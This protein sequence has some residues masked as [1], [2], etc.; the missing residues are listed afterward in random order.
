MIAAAGGT[1]PAAEAEGD[2]GGAGMAPRFAAERTLGKLAKWLRLMGYDTVLENDFPGGRF[3]P[4]IGRRRVLLT[5][6]RRAPQE[7]AA[8]F[9]AANDPVEQLRELAAAGWVAPGDLKPFSRCLR[10]NAPIER[11]GR[12]EV[13]GL[14]PDY[15]W[16]V[17]AAFS[18]CPVCRR[19]YWRGSHTRRG[20]E[21]IARLFGMEGG[22]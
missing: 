11:V 7:T 15:V 6:R 14:V 16:E 19:V 8:V 3:P 21:R 20:L 4:D 1:A 18:R 12:E 22:K 2:E 10:C 5:R 9:I 17:Q 13:Q